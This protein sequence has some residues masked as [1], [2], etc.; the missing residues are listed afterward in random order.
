LAAGPQNPNVNL[1]RGQIASTLPGVR[2]HNT[3]HRVH[4]YSEYNQIYTVAT[5]LETTPVGAVH[6]FD[7]SN[8]NRDL[9]TNFD[10]VGF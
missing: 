1:R 7:T 3:L 6:T 9:S 5:N 8:A 10:V 2:L 4:R